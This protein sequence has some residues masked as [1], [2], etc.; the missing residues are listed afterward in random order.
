MFSRAPGIDTTLP[1]PPPCRDVL[2]V[3]DVIVVLVAVRYWLI[4]YHGLYHY[5]SCALKF[6]LNY[7][8]KSRTAA[9]WTVLDAVEG[10]SL[11]L[12]AL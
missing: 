12:T 1:A 10:I 7:R 5:N 4:S 3:S 2:T 11:Q 9:R 6:Q 8:V